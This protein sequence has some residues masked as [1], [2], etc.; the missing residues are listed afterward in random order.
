LISRALARKSDGSNIK[1]KTGRSFQAPKQF[2]VGVNPQQLVVADFNHDGKPDIATINGGDST[3]SI[4][5]N[6]TPLAPPRLH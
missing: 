3:I 2:G 5:L 4:L 6:T 1:T